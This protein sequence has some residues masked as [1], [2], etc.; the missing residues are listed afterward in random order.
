M[1]RG[2]VIAGIERAPTE[3]LRRDLPVLTEDVRLFDDLNMDSTM[4]LELLMTLEDTIGVEKDAEN[5]SMDDFQTIGTLAD[6]LMSVA[7]ITA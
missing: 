4:A 6:F 2:D 3:V 5:L 7:G 1:D